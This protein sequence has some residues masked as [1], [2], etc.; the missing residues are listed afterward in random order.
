[1]LR[2]IAAASLAVP[3]AAAA[4]VVVVDVD[5]STAMDSRRVWGL[6][7]KYG[8]QSTCRTAGDGPGL[9]VLG[10]RT[11]LLLLLLLLLLYI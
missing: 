4:A 10:P 9:A 5:H 2:S 3:A 8:P 1:M 6:W 7:G 11:Q